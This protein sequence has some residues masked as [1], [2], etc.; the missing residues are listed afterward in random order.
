[1]INPEEEKQKE[2]SYSPE[3]AQDEAD[4]LTEQL[5]KSK[6]NG[7]EIGYEQTE[8][9]VDLETTKASTL[10]RIHGVG[11]PE[12][13]RGFEQA[14]YMGFLEEGEQMTALDSHY[15]SKVDALFAD[16]EL[17]EA[18]RNQAILDIGDELLGGNLIAIRGIRTPS[19]DFIFDNSEVFENCPDDKK[20]RILTGAARQSFAFG[21]EVQGWR[22]MDQAAEISGTNAAEYAAHEKE[23]LEA[24]TKELAERYKRRPSPEPQNAP[25]HAGLDQALRAQGMYLRSH[26]MD[27]IANESRAETGIF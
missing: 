14:V 15:E 2:S 10:D 3:E 25:G 20:L 19:P 22:I 12:V 21:M 11:S 24:Q 27:D 8:K 13:K 6:E 5:A 9:L 26:G 4:R 17:L 7:V 1:M 16:P 23:F 18:D